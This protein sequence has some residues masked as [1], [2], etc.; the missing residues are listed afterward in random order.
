MNILS[1]K[2]QCK[3]RLAVK[4]YISKILLGQFQEEDMWHAY[5]YELG[6]RKYDQNN[7]KKLENTETIFCPIISNKQGLIVHPRLFL[8]I[9]TSW[10][11]IGS[12][13]SSRALRMPSIH[14]SNGSG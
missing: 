1:K 14:T 2:H 8:Y 13:G 5:L 9:P 3:L 11:K 7:T 4:A 6:E 12:T 10:F